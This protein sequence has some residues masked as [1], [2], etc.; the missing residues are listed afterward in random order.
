[1]DLHPGAGCKR[2]QLGVVV[3]LNVI[4]VGFFK[5]ILFNGNKRGAASDLDLP[6]AG[7]ATVRA[8]LDDLEFLFLANEQ[9]VADAQTVEETA[10]KLGDLVK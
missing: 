2:L 4:R 6:T 1:V 7:H 5:R 8:S 9:A 3:G 10:R